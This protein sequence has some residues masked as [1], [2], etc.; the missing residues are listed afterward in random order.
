LLPSFATIL[1]A[2]AGLCFTCAY[3]H[4]NQQLQR[5]QTFSQFMPYLVGKDEEARQV[6]V[7]AIAVLGDTKLAV[8]AAGSSPS[9]G[10]A[11]ALMKIA[12]ESITEDDRK[13]ASEGFA[14]IFARDLN[15]QFLERET[16]EL[17][18][19]GFYSYLLFA[20]EPGP[21]KLDRYTQAIELFDGPTSFSDKPSQM[22]PQLS[23]AGLEAGPIGPSGPT[24]PT[25]LE[26]S[27]R[28]GEL[29]PEPRVSSRELQEQLAGL[30]VI[31][32]PVK[33]A[34]HPHD[35]ADTVL[36]NYDYDHA[37]RILRAVKGTHETGPYVLG[38]LA[39][40]RPGSE[41]IDPSFFKDLSTVPA[42]EAGSWIN[43]FFKLISGSR[44]W[45]RAA[46]K[47][48]QTDLEAKKR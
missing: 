39:P 6:A 15:R 27:R 45:D 44:S 43:K 17:P 22:A 23:G 2:L 35:S 42:E 32:V 19:Y 5:V 10:T 9:Y 33:A 3:Q 38:A 34:I 46:V 8:E 21:E 18:W 7:S 31:Y 36:R 47:Q 30:S 4:S 16:S 1:V 24:G 48:L 40:I 13:R 28:L 20:S 25:G 14:R 26:I 41:L 29:N 11:L 37:R 12:T